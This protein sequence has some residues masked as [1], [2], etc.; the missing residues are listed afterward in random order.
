M[1][2]GKRERTVTVLVF[3]GAVAGIMWVLVSDRQHRSRVITSFLPETTSF[4]LLV[5]HRAV[6]NWDHPVLRENQL[7]DAERN[8][9][10]DQWRQLEQK[11]GVSIT[12]AL[13]F[14]FRSG[15]AF[16][17]GLVVETA[18]PLSATQKRMVAGLPVAEASWHDPNELVAQTYENKYIVFLPR[19]ADRGIAKQPISLPA[20]DV[21]CYGHGVGA[22]TPFGISPEAVRVSG[23]QI[24]ENPEP[25]RC[26]VEQ[27]RG[28]LRIS[29]I[30]DA[31]E[32]RS[33]IS[34]LRIPENL[35]FMVADRS[36]SSYENNS[37]F[38]WY[39][40]AL[41]QKI[42]LANFIS[43][44]DLEPYLARLTVLASTDDGWFM[45]STSTEAIRAVA[46]KL[47]GWFQPRIT[48][49]RLPDRTILREY[50]ATALEPHDEIIGGVPVRVW[51]SSTSTEP[52]V[53][54]HALYSRSE[55]GLTYLTNAFSWLQGQ[56]DDTWFEITRYPAFVQCAGAPPNS[57]LYAA[58]I[59]APFQNTEF[60]HRGYAGFETSA[61]K[62]AISTFCFW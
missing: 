57:P 48:E 15:D 25:W 4:A 42:S 14:V 62:A 27:D 3:L 8:R 19:D 11:L 49:R 44:T 9:I 55:G 45:A 2:F 7:L 1:A 60:S 58:G 59:A 13:P 39:M 47:S 50:E 52:V 28:L 51:S 40:Q 46:E 30:Q 38:Q 10:R 6:F 56:Y 35:Q 16:A 5:S 37:A 41:L 54:G 61:Q 12:R 33:A 22:L 18:A 29:F 20:S 26:S 24:A 17:S 36:L 21:A 23:L 31:A 53:Q 32:D 34:G 43:V